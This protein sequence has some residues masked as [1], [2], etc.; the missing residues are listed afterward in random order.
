VPT[1]LA[2]AASGTSMYPALAIAASS[3]T[4]RIGVLEFFEHV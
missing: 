4:S 2:L 3:A 1:I